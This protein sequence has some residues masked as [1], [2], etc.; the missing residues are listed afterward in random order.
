[1]KF[2]DLLLTVKIVGFFA[3]LYRT[4]RKVSCAHETTELIFVYSYHC[5]TSNKID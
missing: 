1:M 2:T 5:K 4:N 3:N